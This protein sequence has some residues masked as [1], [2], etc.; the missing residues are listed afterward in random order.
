ML[1]STSDSQ[2]VNKIPS[3]WLKIPVPAIDREKKVRN[4]TP[5]LSLQLEREQEK[6]GTHITQVIIPKLCKKT[7][8]FKDPY[9]W[10]KQQKPDCSSLPALPTAINTSQCQKTCPD[11]SSFWWELLQLSQD[12]GS[13][14]ADKPFTHT[15]YSLWQEGITGVNRSRENA[16]TIHTGKGFFFPQKIKWRSLP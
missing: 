16:C 15:S 13:L 6:L 2:A 8:E 4:E 12:K 1:T 10:L 11:Q 14:Y 3:T 5:E 7:E 9:W